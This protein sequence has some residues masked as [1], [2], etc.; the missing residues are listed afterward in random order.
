MIEENDKLCLIFSNLMFYCY[1][2]FKI[3]KLNVLFFLRNS[4]LCISNEGIK[5]Q[6]NLSLNN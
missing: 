4:V 5:H 2:F 3:A 6:F 1:L